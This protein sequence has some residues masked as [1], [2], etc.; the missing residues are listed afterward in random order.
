M[1]N[2]KSSK[3][4]QEQIDNPHILFFCEMEIHPKHKITIKVL[5]KKFR[6]VILV[7]HGLISSITFKSSDKPRVKFEY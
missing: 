1:L 5:T 7:T 3:L 6:Q 2:R 4:L